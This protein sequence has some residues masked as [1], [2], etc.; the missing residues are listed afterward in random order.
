M[1]YDDVKS[2]LIDLMGRAGPSMIISAMGDLI[3]EGGESVAAHN[4]YR[5]S[6][7]IDDEEFMDEMMSHNFEDEDE[8]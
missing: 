1:D 4:L 6:R 5:L 2:E 8:E 3:K 7:Q